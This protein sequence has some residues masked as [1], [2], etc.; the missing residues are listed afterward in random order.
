MDR[1]WIGFELG[2]HCRHALKSG[3]LISG[4]VLRLEFA[5]VWWGC[6]I[7]ILKLY[8]YKNDF[9]Y[10]PGSGQ[11][12]YYKGSVVLISVALYG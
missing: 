9:M 3:L 10:S 4:L 5:S 7:R 8:F 11:G 2:I 1:A 6:D 12:I